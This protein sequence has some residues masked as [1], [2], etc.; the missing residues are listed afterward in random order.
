MVMKVTRGTAIEFTSSSTETLTL[1]S[2]AS[3]AGRQSAEHDRGTGDLDHLYEWRAW[4]KFAT[5]PVVGETVDIYLKTSDGTHDD[6]DDGATDAALSAENK[7]KN[8]QYVGSITVDEA[9]TTP[10]F[11]A[12]G[13]VSITARYIQA[14]VFN[15]TADAL[16]ATAT[17]HGVSFTPIIPK[18]DGN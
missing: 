8:L 2:V 13:T 18:D 6:N 12:S 14:V 15:S 9:S 3:D 5:T 4:C 1:T 11:S 10:E 17:D 7:L 16:S